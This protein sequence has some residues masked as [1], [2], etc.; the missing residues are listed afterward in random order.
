MWRQAISEGED[1]PDNSKVSNHTC[2]SSRRVA[3]AVGITRRVS[4]IRIAAAKATRVL[5][6][7]G[8]PLFCFVS[9]SRAVP[10]RSM[11]PLIATAPSVSTVIAASPIPCR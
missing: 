3:Q 5:R 10:S 9:V 2:G 11:G 1:L 8:A 7:H 6:A 4:A